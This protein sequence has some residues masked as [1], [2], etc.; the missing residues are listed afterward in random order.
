MI[1]CK[2]VIF[3]MDGVIVDSE[4]LHEAAFHAVSGDIG[5]AERHGIHY[6][7]Y[8]GRPDTDLWVDFIAMHKP[9][10]TL[11]QLLRMKSGHVLDMLRA[12]RPIFEGLPKLVAALRERY[13]LALAS[14]SEREVV[15][16]VLEMG[17]LGGLFEFTTSG[18]DVANG[19]P[20][21]D[22]YLRTAARLGVAPR[23]CCAIEDSKPGVAAALAAGM[24]VIAITNTHPAE[25]LSHATKVVSTHREIRNLLLD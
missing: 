4:P 1:C 7:K 16:A 10:Y 9:P 15:D 19:K 5:Y 18:S 24:P 11:E 2:A 23:D 12:R 17:G 13:R 3:D 6:E 25:E 22:I 20:N 8:V 21:P 14:G